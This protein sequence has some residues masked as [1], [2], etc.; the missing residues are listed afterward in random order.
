M[1]DKHDEGIKEMCSTGI[2][3]GRSKL[4]QSCSNLKLIPEVEPTVISLK[5]NA[6][7]HHVRPEWL[8]TFQPP[9]ASS[10]VT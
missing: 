9:Y 1:R 6:E 4:L 7:S 3:F 8:E 2:S 5:N 10:K